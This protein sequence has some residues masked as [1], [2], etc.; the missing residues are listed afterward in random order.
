M[1]AVNRFKM[2]R[3]EFGVEN[4]DTFMSFQE[5]VKSIMYLMQQRLTI[6]KSSK[7]INSVLKIGEYTV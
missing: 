2:Y 6:I 5:T 4:D 7:I 3:S 1:Y